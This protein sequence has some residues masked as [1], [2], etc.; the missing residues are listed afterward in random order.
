MVPV[1]TKKAPRNPCV[2]NMFFSHFSKWP[3][4]KIVK[5]WEGCNF[6]TVPHR[7]V[8][9]ASKHMFKGQGN[10]LTYLQSCIIDHKSLIEDF[11]LCKVAISYKYHTFTMTLLQ[12][13]PFYLCKTHKVILLLRIMN[14]ISNLNCHNTL[15]LR[16]QFHQILHCWNANTYINQIK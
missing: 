6:E 4:L 1:S 8:R 7:K 2:R 14:H 13:L 9:F 10:H 15:K 16:G 5:I 3:P 12:N 11:R